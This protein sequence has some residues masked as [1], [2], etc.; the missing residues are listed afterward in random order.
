MSTPTTEAERT[1]NVTVPE[2]DQA[3]RLKKALRHAGVS[4]S[5]MAEYLGITRETAGRYANHSTRVP[6]Q[7]MRLWALRTGVPLEWLMTGETT[8]AAAPASKPSA[9]TKKGG[10][11]KNRPFGLQGSR[12]YKARTTNFPAALH[13]SATR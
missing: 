6:L 2:F 8:P 5:E 4:V 13:D 1:A 10:S 7:T 11:R 3:D 12:W 9:G